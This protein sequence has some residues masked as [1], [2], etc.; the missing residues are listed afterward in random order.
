MPVVLRPALRVH[1]DRSWIDN[2]RIASKYNTTLY[3]AQEFT[4]DENYFFFLTASEF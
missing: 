2:V 4:K 1:T 3:V